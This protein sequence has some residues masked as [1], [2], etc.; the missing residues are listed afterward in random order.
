MNSLKSESKL[1]WENYLVLLMKTNE[2]K[3]KKKTKL[4]KKE[5]NEGKF[6]A[7]NG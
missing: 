4:K 7:Q 5:N 6:Y 1:K 3:W 2:M